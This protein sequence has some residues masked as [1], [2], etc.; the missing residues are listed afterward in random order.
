MSNRWPS[1]KQILDSKVGHLND[2]LKQLQQPEQVKKSKYG[3]KKTV[4]DDIEFDSEKEAK[5]YKDLKLLRKAGEISFLE[6]QVPF[7]L[8]PNGD[9]SYKYVADFVYLDTRTGKKIVEDCKGMRTAEY[10]RK[11]RLMKRIHK[12]KIL[13]T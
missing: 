12:I 10:K 11:R 2:H 7:E 8:N 6:L 5:R 13:E 9:F 1:I 4:V 3:N